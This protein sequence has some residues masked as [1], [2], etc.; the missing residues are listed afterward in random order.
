M[1]ALLAAATT[2]VPYFLHPVQV[3]LP[4][5]YENK[6]DPRNTV[7]FQRDDGSS[8]HPPSAHASSLS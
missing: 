3:L 8:G 2:V 1:L 6:L 7:L 4:T 5:V